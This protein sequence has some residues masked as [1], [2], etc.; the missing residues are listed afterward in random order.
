MHTK[1]PFTLCRNC[2]EAFAA[3]PGEPGYRELAAAHKC[4]AQPP[5]FTSEQHTLFTAMLM[6]APKALLGAG[7]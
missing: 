6:A 4:A 3:R 1:P 2:W 7:S 5:P